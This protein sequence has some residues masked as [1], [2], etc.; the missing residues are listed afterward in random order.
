VPVHLV[1]GGEDSD[2]VPG[3]AHDDRELLAKVKAF[4]GRVLG[5]G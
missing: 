1:I 5:E 3:V 4:F 2:V